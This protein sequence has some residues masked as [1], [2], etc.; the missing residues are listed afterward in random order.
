MKTDWS[1]LEPGRILEGQYTSPKGAPYGAFIIK[2]KEDGARILLIADSGKETQWEHVSVSVSSK[3]R[4]KIQYEMPDWNLMCMVKDLFWE[5]DEAVI[6]IHPPKQ[7]YVKER[8]SMSCHLWKS[9]RQECIIPEPSLFCGVQKADASS[10][11]EDS[12]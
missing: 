1:H 5:S 3:H 12:V 11:P 8:N 9:K 6:Q 7:E 10:L 4:G 2:R